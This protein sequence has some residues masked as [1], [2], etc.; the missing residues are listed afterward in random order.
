MVLVNPSQL[1]TRYSLQVSFRLG[2]A[3]DRQWSRI[4]CRC[5]KK[6]TL[7]LVRSIGPWKRRSPVCLMKIDISTPETGDR[8]THECSSRKAKCILHMTMPCS[9][10]SNQRIIGLEDPIPITNTS[11]MGHLEFLIAQSTP[12]PAEF[13]FPWIKVESR[14]ATTQSCLPPD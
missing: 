13:F 10:L 12:N 14:N 4:H 3:R 9:S 8:H 6:V 1:V 2:L 7:A 11:D 5:E